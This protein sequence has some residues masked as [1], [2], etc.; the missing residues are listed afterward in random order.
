[1]PFLTFA[2]NIVAVG[3]QTRA[4][5]GRRCAGNCRRIA[6]HI[7]RMAWGWV[8]GG[9]GVTTALHRLCMELRCMLR[10]LPR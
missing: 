10:M 1:M 5:A 9:G 8:H 6:P 2:T 3:E 7:H 4:E